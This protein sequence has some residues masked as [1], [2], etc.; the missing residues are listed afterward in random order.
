M[1][2]AAVTFPAGEWGGR[3]LKDVVPP[4]HREGPDGKLIELPFDWELSDPHEVTIKTTTL[5]VRELVR[6]GFWFP[7]PGATPE[8]RAR[9]G[10][11]AL[12]EA[13][14]YRPDIPL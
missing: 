1:L 7:G 4:Q 9:G 6:T 8:D 11:A 12:R 2:G 13:G 14:L 3:E 10:L 5:L